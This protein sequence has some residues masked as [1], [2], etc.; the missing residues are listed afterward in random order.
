VD[1]SAGLVKVQR[2]VLLLNKQESLLDKKVL[3]V[4]INTLQM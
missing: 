1:V 3:V 4:E 2:Q